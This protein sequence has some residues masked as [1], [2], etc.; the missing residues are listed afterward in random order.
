[1]R[2]VLKS[3][4]RGNPLIL[5]TESTLSEK[6]VLSFFEWD[7]SKGEGKADCNIYAQIWE[8]GHVARFKHVFSS[9]IERFAKDFAPYLRGIVKNRQITVCDKVW[10]FDSFVKPL[11]EDDLR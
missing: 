5:L 4:E 9:G 3:D 10:R 11:S 7:Y 6:Q 1:M 8:N 2:T